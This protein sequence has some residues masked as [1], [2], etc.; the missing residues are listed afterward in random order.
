MDLVTDYARRFGIDDAMPKH[1]SMALG[2][3]ET[4]LIRMT[5]AYSMLVNGG[6]RVVPT[7]IDRVQDRS[8]ERRVG[9]ESG[10]RLRR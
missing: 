6:K 9:E 2:A 5:T 7:L 3:G 4:T 1:L 10:T 8:E